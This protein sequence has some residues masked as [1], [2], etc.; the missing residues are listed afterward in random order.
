MAQSGRQTIAALS[1]SA[2]KY[3]ST[4]LCNGCTTF[5]AAFALTSLGLVALNSEW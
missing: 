3:L 1:H 4:S 2:G 5:L